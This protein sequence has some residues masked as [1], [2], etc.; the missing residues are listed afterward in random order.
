MSRDSNVVIV[1]GGIVGLACAYK[2]ARDGVAVTL[3]EY[4]KAGMQATNAAAGM[5][6]PI[7][8][9]AEAPDAMT[10]W[11]MEALAGYPELVASLQN[12]CGFD[13]EFVQDGILKIAFDDAGAAALH[14]RYTWQRDMNIPLEWLDAATCH[15][16]E[17]RLSERVVAGVFSPTE[18]TISNQLLALALQRAAI[19]HGA[20]IHERAPVT[21]FT[22]NN[23][24]V[25]AVEAGGETFPCDTL[26]IAAGARSAQIAKL[27]GVE[28]PVHPI[29]GQMIAFGGMQTP[30]RQV[31][32]GP[33]GYLVPRA[34]GLI[35]AGAT[36]EDVGFRRR[37][38]Q[39][40][41][42]AMRSMAV[43]LVPQLA[44]ATVHFDW[45]GL[46]P[47][48]PDGLPIIGPLPDSNVIAATGHYRN[49][50]LLGP[51]T[52]AA[53]ARGVTT[54]DWSAVPAEFA[55]ERFS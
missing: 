41:T 3:I 36:V 54:D 12:Q 47:C 25:T 44:A 7:S 21:R 34:N 9:E 4:G 11:G 52:G 26:I 23:G 20:M 38:T 28:L 55:P 14:R 33:K 24:R 46:R 49:G 5:L 17:P 35:F 13:L 10:R 18:A 29:R 16:F 45:A 2:L 27:A 37:T 15:E 53:V 19:A 39:A 42:R 1:G 22:C 40:G 6:T 8:G 32:W 51:I 30:I 48:T 50:I 31:V 43:R